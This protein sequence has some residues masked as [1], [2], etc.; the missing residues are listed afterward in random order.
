[1]AARRFSLCI[2]CAS[3][4]TEADEFDPTDAAHCFICRG[5]TKRASLIGPKVLRQATKYDFRTFSVG[6]IIS[7][8]VQEREDQVRSELQMRGGQTIKS[9]LS[10]E[11]ASFI[12]KRTKRRVDRLHPDLT[13]LVD[14]RSGSVS[15]VAK[16]LF[17]YGRY[18]KPRG[19]SQR[20]EL[21]ERCGGRGC[22]DC[23]DGYSKSPSMEEVLGRRLVR[24]LHSTAVKFTWLGSEDRE[25]LVRAPGRPF[26]AEVKNP[27]RRLIPSAM[28]LATGMGL[29][30]VAGLKP[31]KG[32]PE[33]IPSFVFK[34]EALVEPL[35]AFPADLRAASRMGGELVEYRNNKGKKVLKKVYSV[36]VKKRGKLLVAEM[37]IDG[38]LPVKRLVSGE[39]TSP[40]LSEVLKTPL[41]CQRFDI[42][43]VW[44]SRGLKFGKI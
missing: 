15:M 17:V 26:I 41:K 4:Q 3:R 6:I 37:K 25:S 9:Q 12:S 33:S 14:L 27:R 20:R 8:E 13:V 30:R 34:T 19:V 38:G 10:R 29:S 35:E 11:I 28:H 22:D 21:C 24:I 1:M 5:L 40:S 7:P 43:R 31:L 42:L 44:E 32:R 36:R 23:K 39:S 16:S 2:Q 18:S